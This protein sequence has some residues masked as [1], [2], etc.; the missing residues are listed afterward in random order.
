M[1]LKDSE[2]LFFLFSSRHQI[3]DINRILLGLRDALAGKST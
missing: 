1:R 2:D 3:V